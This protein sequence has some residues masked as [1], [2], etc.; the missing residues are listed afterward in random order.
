MESMRI[1]HEEAIITKKVDNFCLKKSESIILQNTFK[2]IMIFF[3][4]MFLLY[5]KNRQI[6]ETKIIN[7]LKNIAHNLNGNGNANNKYDLNFKYHLYERE[8]IT[9]KMKNYGGWLLSNNEPYFINGIIRKFKPKKCLE[10]GVAK[11]GSAIIILNALKDINDSFLISLDLN[12]YNS[13]GK[14]YIGEN[15]KKY[16]P[17]LTNN[18]K[19]QLYTGEQPHKFLD[20]LN[21]KFDF[22]FLDTVH[23]TPGELAFILRYK[24]LI[25]KLIYPK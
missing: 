16:F 21:L 5:Y 2:L 15:V 11:G 14:Y 3:F 1:T 13:D 20:K 25:K 12:S 7:E 9:E 8:M 4:F 17:E 6:Y 24:C 23:I 10:I 22:L 19:W 18:N